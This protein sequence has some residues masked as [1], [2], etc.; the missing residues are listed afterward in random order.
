MS[1][2]SLIPFHKGA[3][4]SV[5]AIVYTLS[6]N[7]Y[8]FYIKFEINTGSSYLFPKLGNLSLLH[9]MILLNTNRFVIQIAKIL[10]KFLVYLCS[11]CHALT[12]F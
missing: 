9:F 4:S 5:C 2:F 8:E 12:E 10:G 6:N 7:K 1:N 11:I 3:C